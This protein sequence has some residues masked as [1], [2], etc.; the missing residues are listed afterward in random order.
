LQ[1]PAKRLPTIKTIDESNLGRIESGSFED[2]IHRRIDSD[3]NLV[4]LEPDIDETLL[5]QMYREMVI[6]RYFDKI[7]TRLSL[8]RELI[9]YPPILGQEASQ[10]GYALALAQGDWFL[11]NYRS[12]GALLTLGFPPEL[13]LLHFS[14][15]ERGMR[16]PDNL[17]I[18]PMVTQVS[19]HLTQAC[20]I[21]FS[22]KIAQNGRVTLATVGDGGTSKG[23]FHE[24]LNMAGVSKLPV[25]FVIE[26]N[27]WAIS[28]RRQKQTASKT[29]AQKAIAY[30]FE[31]IIVD[32]N[33]VLAVYE[34]ATYAIAKARRGEGPTL[35]ECFT[36]RMGLHSTSDLVSIKLVPEEELRVWRAGDPIAR[37]RAYLA[38]RGMLTDE[39]DR[40]IAKEVE[41]RAE[42]EVSKFR[43]TTLP[44]STDLFSYTYSA[45][46][47]A[48]SE[49]MKRQAETQGL[50]DRRLDGGQV[51][52]I[53]HAINLA[54]RQEM[55]RNEKIVVFGEDVG[56]E[57]G[58]FQVTK[59]LQELF[60]ED[61]VFDTPVS[62]V[63]IAGLF[64]GL[65]VGGFV[66]VA[67]FQFD[68]FV[69][70][71]LDQIINH[72]GRIRNRSR[73]R[74][75]AGGVIRFPY[76]AGTG[77]PESHAESPEAY[78]CHTPGVKVVV[79]S[80]A[81]DAKGLLISALRGQDPVIFMEPKKLYDAP[82]MPVPSEEYTVPLDRARVA[83]EGSDLTLI[84][85]GAMMTQ[86]LEAA[87]QLEAQGTSSEVIDLM[88]LSPLDFDTV[89]ASV[90]KT[91]RAI[92]VH[93]A[94]RTCGVGAE[95]AARIVERCTYSLKSPVVR[96]T[97]YDVPMPQRRLES[98][99]L[100]SV[101]RILSA[102]R[103][104]L[105]G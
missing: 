66:P 80:N 27:Q 81:Y 62:E 84:S 23:D 75:S 3:G 74:F 64:L 97:G 61:R 59:S 18:M 98:Y 100:P 54:L 17:N 53:R 87:K 8:S 103:E 10:A 67:E 96:V 86:T 7:L 12:S 93:E 20:G 28:V 32:G 34:A 37:Y 73:G 56:K 58:V 92:I 63:C 6:Q 43:S 4:G 95:V 9:S 91:G 57:G 11:P 99:Y 68:G 105:R 44:D 104:V 79:P 39:V 26:N 14:G 51:M 21:A 24:A 30:G 31:G 88:T 41:V 25:V 33:D 102:S 13:L 78:F 90:E 94:P 40:Q 85:Y 52:N 60:G 82:K 65:A 69:Y 89:K 76:G 50:V 19:S 46:S 35:I 48:P 15:D 36:Y 1:R 49:E 5:L 22:N 72:I 38:Q 83:R 45:G 42:R 77:A 16:I 70:S 71:A 101:D 2:L 55:A 47:P 29:L